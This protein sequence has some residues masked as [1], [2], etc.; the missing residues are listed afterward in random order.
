MLQ[1]IKILTSIE[2]FFKHAE[3]QYSNNEQSQL[4]QSVGHVSLKE[5]GCHDNI[6]KVVWGNT[7]SI[8]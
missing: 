4:V 6:D 1:A 7:W 8:Y 5:E 3:T 2:T